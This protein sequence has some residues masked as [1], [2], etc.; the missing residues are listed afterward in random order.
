M[1][2]EFSNGTAVDLKIYNT[3]L[4]L[5]IQKNYKHLS[6]LPVPC[7][8]QDNPYYLDNLLYSDLVDLLCKNAKS[9]GVDIDLKR[10]LAHDQNYFNEIHK[11]YEQKYNGDTAW[12][13]FH[14]HIHLCELYFSPHRHSRFC[15]DYR[16]QSGP[17]EKPMQF[18]WVANSVTD[19]KAGSVFVEWAELGKIPYTY[20]KNNEPN[21]VC[22][23]NELAKP[24]ITLKPKIY[25]ALKDIDRLDGLDQPGFE[26]WWQQ[27]H[28]DWT[29]HWNIP[30]WTL[31]HMF[32]AVVIGHTDHVE[33]LNAQLKNNLFPTRITMQ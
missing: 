28:N 30:E 5:V 27:F 4:G 19:I 12:L 3:D 10:A 23:L 13:N 15:I 33:L 2:L 16:E 11:I 31:Q 8:Q 1:I 21:D 24:W 9:V 32:G 20:W 18:S 7:R 25:I 6:R 14:E 17:L 26:L 22:R 29:R